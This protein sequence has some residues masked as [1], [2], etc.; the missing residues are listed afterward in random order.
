MR[1]QVG[2]TAARS[3]YEAAAISVWAESNALRIDE[4]EDSVDAALN[5]AIN[6]LSELSDE[7]YNALPPLQSGSNNAVESVPPTTVE[8]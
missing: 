2:L 7:G 6:R 4:L 1:H 8:S 5:E 3:D